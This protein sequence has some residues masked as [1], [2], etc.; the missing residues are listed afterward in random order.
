MVLNYCSYITKVIMPIYLMGFKLVSP[1][2]R[3][4]LRHILARTI[5]PL[6]KIRGRKPQIHQVSAKTEHW[7]RVNT[8]DYWNAWMSNWCQMAKYPR[9][10]QH[11]MS[12]WILLAVS[13]DLPF[14]KRYPGYSWSTF[15]TEQIV[16]DR[17]AKWV[18][19]YKAL[20]SS[21]SLAA[22]SPWM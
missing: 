1:K 3:K 10:M 20:F 13:L 21:W 2:K 4:W 7:C 15:I 22:N 9:N 5:R 19:L 14:R 6:L 11:S 18:T 8:N 17:Y 16:R 12:T